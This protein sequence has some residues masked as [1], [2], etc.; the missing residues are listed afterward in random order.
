M[1]PTWL[2]TWLPLILAA[3]T[4]ESAS[5]VAAKLVRMP[6]KGLRNNLYMFE[7]ELQGEE[8]QTLQLFQKVQ[9]PVADPEYKA[10]TRKD[11]ARALPDH[12]G[13]DWG[14]PKTCGHQSHEGHR[15]PKAA[16]RVP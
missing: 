3:S 12:N 9:R 5:W 16:L 1:Q 8:V 10:R 11:S 7:S 15:C 13:A 14:A 4:P 2:R 6:I